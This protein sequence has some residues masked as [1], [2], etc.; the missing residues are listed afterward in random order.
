VKIELKFHDFLTAIFKCIFIH[1]VCPFLCHYARTRV[2]L[3]DCH[4]NL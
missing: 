2:S 3:T 1:H 4:E